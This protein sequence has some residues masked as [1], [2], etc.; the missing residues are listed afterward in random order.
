MAQRSNS[1]VDFGECD[2]HTIY[3]WL[4]A[5]SLFISGGHVQS[6]PLPGQAI[7]QVNAVFRNTGPRGKWV[8][9]TDQAGL[10]AAPAARHRGCAFGDLD[11]DGRVDVVVS[12]IGRE[13]EIWMNRSEKFRHWLDI[14][15][16]GTK[17]N[18]DGIG[19]RI[20]VTTKSGIQYNH[21]TTSV[22]YASSSD[23][24]VHFGLGSDDRA[25]EVEIRWPS[26]TIQRLR[27]V[28]ADRVVEVKEAAPERKTSAALI[29][30]R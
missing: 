28:K 23:G 18:R 24:P 7:D 6:L 1:Y 3:R 10:T 21:M 12:A 2:D 26:G 15:L 14:A 17:S 5:W 30:R 4:S 16:H 20:K 19:A 11:G 9:L 25:E 29:G 22:G 27:H 8:A 13:A